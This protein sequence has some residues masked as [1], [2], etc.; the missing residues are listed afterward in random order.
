[1]RRFSRLL[2]FTKRPIQRY[3]SE[4]P[5]VGTGGEAGKVPTDF[6]QATGLERLEL[7]ASYRGEKIFLDQELVIN[8]KGTMKKPVM[9]DSLFEDRIVGCSGFPK[10]DH[11]L[12]WMEVHK[13]KVGRCLECG[14][15][16]KLNIV[17]QDIFPEG[18]H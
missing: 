7:L 2:Q 12:I 17:S 9:V 14:Q 16:F 8:E 4:Q 3:Y 15:V 11:E 13:D 10:G 6:E 18:E 1:M 5:I